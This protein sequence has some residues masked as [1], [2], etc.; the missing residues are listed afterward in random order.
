MMRGGTGFSE[1]ASNEN[2]IKKLACDLCD[3]TNTNK[4]GMKKFTFGY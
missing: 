3:F 1:E 2:E 4:G